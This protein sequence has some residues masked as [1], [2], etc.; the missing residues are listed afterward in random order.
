VATC[1]VGAL[2]ILLAFA[3]PAAADT[4]DLGVAGPSLAGTTA[5]TGS[6][7]ESK[8]WWN[9]GHWWASMWDAATEDYYIFKLDAGT[10]SWVR[11]GTRL[12]P[13]YNSRADTLWDGA[14]LYVASHVFSTHPAA[15]FPSRLYRFSYDPTSQTYALDPGFPVQINDLKT[16]TLVIAK[17]PAGKLW[18]TWVIGN[19]VFVNRS[20]ASDADWGDPFAL[21]VAGS[22]DVTP[23]DISSIITVANDVGIMWSN[24]TR[25][26]FYFS[27]HH[28]GAARTS[29][30]AGTQALQGARVAND[31]ISLKADSSG[32]VYAVIK[33]SAIASLAPYTMVLKRNPAGTWTHSVVGLVTDSHTR[34]I[35]LLDDE[36]DRLYVFASAPCCSGGTIYEKS[37]S[38]TTLSFPAGRGTPLIHDADSPA[39]NDPTSTKQNVDSATGLLVLASNDATD[40]YWHAYKSLATP[41]AEITSGPS[42][43][44][45]DHDATFEFV[46]TPPGASFTCSLDGAAFTPCTSPKTY[47]GLSDSAH[48]FSVSADGGTTTASRTWLVDTTAPTLLGISAPG[49]THGFRLAKTIKVKWSASDAGAGV[50]VYRVRYR[51]TRWDGVSGRLVAWKSGTAETTSGALQGRAGNTYCFSFRARDSAGNWSSWSGAVC[52]AI[53]LDDR[54]LSPVGSWRRGSGTGFYLSTFSTSFTR[55]STLRIG[56]VKPKRL[57]LVAMRCS[58]CG[59]V[60]V[61][62]RGRLLKHVDLSASRTRKKQVIV[63]GTFT[64]LV[65]GKVKV[66]VTSRHR[67][68]SVDGL[69]VAAS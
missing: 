1:V 21:N 40:R 44:V 60:N 55:S 64:S 56:G 41:S 18:A 3:G 47:T 50:E 27:T 9:D 10:Q 42:G 14:H 46:S 54:G 49:Q 58:K 32:S 63:L 5:P 30:S 61:Y 24:Q 7:P 45:S 28:T 69:G 51:K 26:A 22:T 15:G 65:T 38:T 68:V 34:P 66:V 35:L 33:T 12:D 13:R 37:A 8:A 4:G 23:D 6:K 25:D 31:H 11:T 39:L 57:A 67:V 53:P 43:A 48:V 62:W 17:D 52:A 29:W 59:S 19:K 2:L 16:E 36:H 20:N